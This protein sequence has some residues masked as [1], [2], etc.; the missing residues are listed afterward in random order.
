MDA[1]EC[2]RT[3]R[4]VRKFSAAPVEYDKLLSIID[5][6]HHAP[7]SGNLQNWKF[8][9]L[10]ERSTIK[11]LPQH[12]LGQEVADAPVVIVV[13][14]NNEVCEK[15]YGLRGSRLYSIQNTAAA[16]ENLLLAAHA[17]GLGA[18]WIG[19]FDEDKIARLCDCPDSARPQALI[20]IGYPDEESA[21]KRM[22]PLTDV[23]YF[24]K[25][26][27]RLKA[28]HMELQD[29]SDEISRR[30]EDVK[31]SFPKKKLSRIFKRKSRL[32]IGRA[33]V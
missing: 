25:Y 3:R 30:V 16:I 33:H 29:Y 22:K 24:N 17:L 32:Q 12:C 31:E 4:S 15:H 10:T 9:I 23:V 27:N 19:A 7:S 8:I 26:G 18:C 28:P 2:I 1:M 20:S 14:A 13:C 21:G 5:A 6:A 11:S